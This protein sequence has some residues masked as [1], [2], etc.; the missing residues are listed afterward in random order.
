MIYL[1]LD[2]SAIATIRTKKDLFGREKII[3]S[4]RKMMPE[5]LMEDGQISDEDKFI[6]HLRETFASGYPNS[7]DGN[8]I[9][10]FIPDDSLINTRFIV[11]V[12]KSYSMSQQVSERA[13]KI[14][15]D[16][17]ANYENFYKELESTD[18]AIK[19]LYTALPIEV[20]NKQVNL[21]SKAGLSVTSLSTNSF[22]LSSL[23]KTII[24]TNQI[25][26]YCALDKNVSHFVIYDKYGP[27][28]TTDKK[29]VQKNLAGEIAAVYKKYHQEDK[30]DIS[31]VIISGEKSLELHMDEFSKEMEIPVSKMGDLLDQLCMKEKIEFDIGGLPKM[32]FGYALSTLFF[33]KNDTLPNFVQGYK[34]PKP[35]IRTEVVKKENIAQIE[36]V[37]SKKE[38][39]S[40]TVAKEQKTDLDSPVF[41]D[42]IVEY[43]PSQLSIVS[44]KKVF[45]LLIMAAIISF[46]I[47]I[48]L[49]SASDLGANI[50][51]ISKPTATPTP[52][53]EPTVTPT[54]TIDP[55]LKR[56]DIKLSVEN[57][58]DKTGYAK[59]TAQSLEELGYNNIVI[60]NADRDDYE[61]TVIRIR[62]DKKNYLQLVVADL[63][64]KYDTSQIETLDESSK[65]DVVIVLGKK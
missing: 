27:L 21:F 54:P 35:D 7:I 15:P 9:S 6:S 44:N 41:T 25:Y 5:K 52:T 36:T 33:S 11:N 53:V 34:M 43:K 26:M 56:I 24:P 63:S 64:S 37:T 17:I 31:R 1:N 58:T 32:Y 23:F 49:I 8:K 59:E 42:Q 65:Y 48:Y 28:H 46:V 29:T 4:S 20:I 22:S 18:G 14:L 2:S 10:I 51:F 16:D 57:G 55:S 19:V 60:S 13:K 38:E 39:E 30:L 47:G 3:S 45:Y 12:D 62:D 61:N 40:M 50:P